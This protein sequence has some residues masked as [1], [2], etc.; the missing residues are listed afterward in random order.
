LVVQDLTKAT[1]E[2]FAG[3]ITAWSAVWTNNTGQLVT[4]LVEDPPGSGTFTNQLAT[5]VIELAYHAL[6]VDGAMNSVMPV[7]VHEFTARSANTLLVDSISVVDSMVMDSER[8][9]LGTN[10]FLELNSRAI[11]WNAVSAPTV[12][13]FTNHG[14][15]FASRDAIFGADRPTPY[16][17]VVNRGT[18][19]TFD[20][21]IRAV[22]FENTGSVLAVGPI[23]LEA[24]SVRCEAGLINAGTDLYL[25]GHDLKFR[26]QRC[27][28]GGALVLVATNSLADSGDGADNTWEVNSGLRLMRKPTFGDL[29][30]TT[31]RSTAPRYAE[32]W[33]TWAG[34]NR[35][36]DTAG[37]SNNVALGR[38][39]LQTTGDGR[40]TF[41]GTGSNNGL[42]V[43]LLEFAGPALQDLQSALRISG[44]L[45]IYFADSNLP[46]E[47]LDGLFA[48]AGA[49]AGRLRWVKEFAGPNSGMDLLLSDGRIIRV[50]RALRNST[51]IDSDGD[52]IPNN[53][54]LDPFTPTITGMTVTTSAGSMSTAISFGAAARSVYQVEYTSDLAPPDWRPLGTLT[55]EATITNILTVLDTNLP[56]DTLQR[57]Y[58][59]RLELNP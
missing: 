18:F 53:W 24:R 10:A 48:D 21:R 58:R 27:Y 42:Y 25:A 20:T 11:D 39:I 34:E 3:D 13:Y 30:G 56:P 57:F 28:A 17:S 43:D 12:L 22:E 29:L 45:V 15:F 55:N 35:G 5:N 19:D 32:V 40:L 31:V 36:T 47:E 6:L 54:D 8:V 59:L 14:Y 7:Q 2:R 51:T 49:P 37:F 26:Q 23:S 1:V 16:T 38:L 33:H 52:G 4:N 50:N 41:S 9:T 46:V 44:N